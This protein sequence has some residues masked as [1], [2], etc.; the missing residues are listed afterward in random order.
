MLASRVRLS[1]GG[2]GLLACL[3][4]VAA[5]VAA[6]GD[7]RADSIT[8]GAG[9]RPENPVLR[10]VTA[11]RR[12]GLVVG[13]APGVAFAGAS[14]YPNDAVL[15]GNPAFYSQ[16]PLLV[17][18]ST[19]YFLMGSFTDF[20][21]F[22]PVVNVALFES[23]AWKSTGLGI[24]F[25]A[26]TFPLLHLYPRLA[27]LSLYGQA[28]VGVTELRL[29]SGA[30]PSADGTQSYAAIGVHHEWRVFQAG[31]GHFAA[32]PYAEYDA[33]FATSAERHWA[34]VGLRVAWYGGTV[35]ADHK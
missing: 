1:A 2:C 4:G 17:G 25:R 23:V 35:T 28:G 12:A 8:A 19:S 13:V 14:G 31:G 27:D 32:G 3:A 18:H 9:D 22:G 15:V 34:A 10:A 24:G 16:S 26:E 29:K 6:P 33:I 7:A 20:V 5:D 21:S 11:E 30:Y